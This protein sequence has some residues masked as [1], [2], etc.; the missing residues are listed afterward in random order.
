[1]TWMA[2][3]LAAGRKEVGI[4]RNAITATANIVLKTLLG[5]MIVQLLTAKHISKSYHRVV[6]GMSC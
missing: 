2:C 5:F 1:V 3:S 4:N 6:G